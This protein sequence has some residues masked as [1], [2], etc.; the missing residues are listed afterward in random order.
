VGGPS[1][2][3][4]FDPT[5]HEALTDAAWNASAARA[6]IERIAAEALDRF[7]P[8]HGWPAH[9]RYSSFA[10]DCFTMRCHTGSSRL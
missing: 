8:G 5:R 1:L 9:A 10:P 3:A 7:Q 2:T 4:L 6:A